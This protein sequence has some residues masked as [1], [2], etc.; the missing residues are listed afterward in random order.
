MGKT[1]A[2]GWAEAPLPDGIGQDL[3]GFLIRD[4]PSIGQRDQPVARAMYLHGGG[5]GLVWVSLDVLALGQS[6]VERIRTAAS[7]RHKLPPRSFCI[8]ATHTH[9][10]P[11]TVFL[12]NCGV[13]DRNWLRRLEE[14]LLD[15]IGHA[16]TGPKKRV[17]LRLA[18]I[19]APGFSYNRQSH[20]PD[21]SPLPEADHPVP[22]DT[23]LS[24]IVADEAK[25]GKP[26]AAVVH[27]PCHATL[28]HDRLVSAD[29]PG[30]LVES[31]CRNVG[32]GFRCLFMQG[33]CADVNPIPTGG[34]PEEQVAH[35]GDGLA[36]RAAGLIVDR[37]CG[38]PLTP[39]LNARLRVV[40]LPWE[41]GID[42]EAARSCILTAGEWTR[43]GRV[44]QA[45]H[46][47]ARR[48]L[49]ASARGWWS[50][51]VRMPVQVVTL[52]ELAVAAFGAEV[53]TQTASDL[54]AAESGRS[55]LVAGYANDSVGYLVPAKGCRQGTYE[56]D[57]AHRFYGY[58]DRFSTDAEAIAR[59]CAGDILGVATMR[60]PGRR[61]TRR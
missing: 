42:E 21:G 27:Y 9:S 43:A 59:T 47:W 58:P 16:V 15:V 56:T 51:G 39:A 31:V 38:T 14:T 6:F 37:T 30:R 36:E 33:A 34:T 28:F 60:W 18:Q 57:R 46:I 3:T 45:W 35:M 19:D 54:R 17:R 52:G 23:T 12:A 29:W 11:A 22:V 55:V 49:V 8:A 13:V 61:R 50:D 40:A 5:M 53:F 2:L 20:A 32:P 44:E 1:L 41:T 10:A 7:R 24:A 48:V 26:T 25:T 4:N